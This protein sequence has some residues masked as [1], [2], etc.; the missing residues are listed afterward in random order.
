MIGL[1][2]FALKSP[3]HI[4][5]L[6]AVFAVVPM[7]YV[8][9]AALVA[10]TTLRHGFTAGTRTLL[11]AIGGALVS[12]QLTG[13]P[14]SI[15]VLSISTLLAFVLRVTFSWNRTLIV[16]AVLGIVLALV[17][18]AFMQEQFNELLSSVQELAS[19]GDQSSPGWAMI[20]L[21]KPHVG[22]I[23][24][25]SQLFEA[26]LSL[27]IARYW[28]AGLFNPGGFK[29][30]MHQLRFTWQE[31]VFLVIAIIASLV[32]GSAAMLLLVIPL[33]FAGF[34]LVHGIVAKLKLAGQ[35]LIGFYIAL[36]LLNQIIL[37]LLMVLVCLDS[38]FDFRKR[39][40]KR[41]QS[42]NE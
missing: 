31:M 28:Q 35:W 30:E 33:G 19:G 38:I 14:L 36:V 18:Q 21:V 11:F 17:A 42:E 3:L 12:W 8:L 39:I 5:I 15:L 41:A 24:L 6:A 10:L 4:G 34:A 1:A 32:N 16:G 26:L 22:F 40:D 2:R 20:D 37:P 9:S 25:A 13:V 7:L 27:I 29:A 23:M